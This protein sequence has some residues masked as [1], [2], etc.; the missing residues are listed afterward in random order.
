MGHVLRS[1]EEFFAGQGVLLQET[2]VYFSCMSY[3]Y[4][5]KN[6]AG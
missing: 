4:F 6:N 3:M 1:E 2:F 5:K